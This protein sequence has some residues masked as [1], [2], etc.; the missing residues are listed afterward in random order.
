MTG[1]R[2]SSRCSLSGLSPPLQSGSI[3]SIRSRS[4]SLPPKPPRSTHGPRLTAGGFLFA[5]APPACLP[6]LPA[7]PAC[8][9]APPACLPRLPAC[10]ACL[11]A[12][13]VLAHVLPVKLP[14]PQVRQNGPCFTPKT[15]RFKIDSKRP[16]RRSATPTAARV[17]LPLFVGISAHSAFHQDAPIGRLNRA[18]FPKNEL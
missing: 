8:L 1:A 12:S 11:P 10:P 9:P 15:K 14:W 5:P 6:R 13:P 17:T 18:K 7:C 2:R 16:Q 4:P 3:R